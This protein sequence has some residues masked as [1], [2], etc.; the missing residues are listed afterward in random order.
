MRFLQ[1]RKWL[2]STLI[3]MLV[4]SVVP[5]ASLR[6]QDSGAVTITLTLPGITRDSIT[7][8]VISDFEAANP[9]VKVQVI[10][11]DPEI[12]DAALG[13]DKHFEELQKYVS[14]AD[15]LYVNQTIMSVEATRAGYFLDLSPLV[16][17]YNALNLDHVF[18]S[19]T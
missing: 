16:N 13:L 8:Q 19:L 5:L 11:S 15:V 17:E 7:D 14:A 6:A 18:P 1:L 9:G 3:V 2:L 12:P 4:I 10:A